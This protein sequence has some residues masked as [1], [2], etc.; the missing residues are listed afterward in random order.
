MKKILLTGGA[1][2][3]GTRFCQ[4]YSDIY[5]ITVLD[6]F[7]FGDNL[8]ENVTKVKKD[9]SKINEKDLDGYDVVI[10]MAGLS[11]D[12]MASFRPDLNFVENSA[13]PTYLAYMSKQ[14][15]IKKFIGASSCSV[16]G[17]T[18]NKT[19]TEN[20][21]LKPSY[22]YGVSK[23]QFERGIMLLEDDN[24]KP[25]LLRKG[26]VG[27]WSK[28]MRFDLVVNT[29]I[30][31]ALT[32]KQI[33]VNNSNLWRP[34]IDIRD[35][36]GAYKSV[37]ESDDNISGIYNLSGNNFTIGELGNIIHD[38]LLQ[39]DINVDLVINNVEDFRNY[40]VATNLIEDVFQFFPKYHP[41]DTVSEILQYVLTDNFDFTND[42][43][44]NINTF[45]RV[46]GD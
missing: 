10:F 25:V 1:G 30:M 27:G 28:R 31:T 6:N 40:K 36:V 41:S 15:G 19:L 14:V 2:Y 22:P 7:W 34:L 35:V 24:F 45:K 17:F 8:P 18:K 21:N 46:V 9:I 39:N 33:I 29:M 26:T 20:S 44:Y 43:F 13:V 4:E 5:K 32:K 42:M 11:N 12:P 38:I 37:I 23:L 3:I 16:Y